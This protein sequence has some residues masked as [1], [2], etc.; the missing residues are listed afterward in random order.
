M[1]QFGRVFCLRLSL[2][3]MVIPTVL[4]G[5]IPNYSDIGIAAT[6]IVFILRAMQGISVG[7]ETSTALVYIYEEAP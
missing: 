4:F 3:T 1:Y 7:G 2:F 5:C 6:V